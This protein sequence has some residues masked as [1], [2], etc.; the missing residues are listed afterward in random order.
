MKALRWRIFTLNLREREA[1]EWAVRDLGR[2][3][4]FK[5]HSAYYKCYMAVN[6]Q[7]VQ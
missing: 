2:K 5:E 3:C 6:S 1:R 7:P 4:D